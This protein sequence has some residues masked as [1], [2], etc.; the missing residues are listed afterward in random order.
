MLL[1][2]DKIRKDGGTQMRTHLNDA[3]VGDYAERLRAGVQLPDVIVYYDGETHW[4]AEGFH[5]CAAHETIGSQAVPV[6]V[7]S[8]TRR[9]A[10]LFACGANATHGLP[11]SNEDKKL[12]VTTLLSDPEWGARSDRWIADTAHVDPGTVGK[13]RAQMNPADRPSTGGE[14]TRQGRDGKTRKAPE[15]RKPKSSPP[16]APASAPVA[17]D[18]APAITTSD[19]RGEETVAGDDC[20]EIE[21]VTVTESDRPSAPASAIKAK[22]GTMAD[23]YRSM[24]AKTIGDVKMLANVL[25]DEEWDAFL[26]QLDKVVNARELADKPA[27]RTVVLDEDASGNDQAA[28]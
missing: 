15:P 4:L 22:P 21:N 11:R 17:R 5:R 26:K 2:I 12:A 7:R 28:E 8:G 14:P 9:D 13:Y 10:V 3:V 19:A 25:P 18:P 24:S 20:D 1:G 27:E 6:E 23:A 16:S